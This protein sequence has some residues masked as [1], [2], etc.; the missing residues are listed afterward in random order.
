VRP[1]EDPVQCGPINKNIGWLD[2]FNR[3]LFY[4]ECLNY[5][6]GVFWK[7]M[8]PSISHKN[9]TYTNLFVHF[10]TLTVN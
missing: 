8:T 7:L 6:G 10:L 9:T 5:T 3:K 1:L 2:K 4:A